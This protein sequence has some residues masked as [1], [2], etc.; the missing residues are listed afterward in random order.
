MLLYL[1][2]LQKEKNKINGRND[3][4]TRCNIFLDIL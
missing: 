4:E 2:D 3:S 1:L